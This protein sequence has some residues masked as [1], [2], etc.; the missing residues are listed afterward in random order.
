MAKKYS[1]TEMKRANKSA[2]EFFFSPATM[3]FTR[4]ARLQAVYDKRGK[5]NYIKVAYPQ[6]GGKILWHRFDA[7][8]GKI[9]HCAAPEGVR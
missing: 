3:A 8:S 4:G 2:G 7:R 6:L 1:I 9:R 5:M